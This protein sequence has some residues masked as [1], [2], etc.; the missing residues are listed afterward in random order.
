MIQT[1]FSLAT[2]LYL[3]TVVI[4]AQLSSCL[5]GLDVTFPSDSAFTAESQAFNE[6][7]HY[8]PA[9]IAFP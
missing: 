4:N 8:T 7:L 9:A 6:R 5:T 2:I 1:L 3:H